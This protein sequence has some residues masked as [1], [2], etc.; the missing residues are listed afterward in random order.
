MMVKKSH[1]WIAAGMVSALMLCSGCNTLKECRTPELNLPAEIIEEGTDSASLADIEWFE[2]YSDP[3]LRH[4][5][6][7]TL[8][9]NRNLQAAVARINQLHELYGA[10]KAELLPEIGENLHIKNETKYERGHSFKR[11]SEYGALA[12][13]SWEADIWGNLRWRSK[14][15]LATYKASVEDMRALRIILI[16]EAASAYYRL[17][18]YDNELT[19]VKRTLLTRNEEK[20]KAKLR[21]EGGL[22]SEIVYLQAQVEYNTARSLIPGLERQIE[23]CESALLTLMG[24]YP[25]EK[26]ERSRNA[27]DIELVTPERIP[28]GLPSS[29]LVRRPDLRASEA[30]LSRALAAVGVAYTNRFPRL[31]ISMEGGLEAVNPGSLFNSP[32]SFINGALIGPIFDFNKRKRRYKAAVAEYD[33]ARLN[34]E[35]NVL[36]AFQEV[37][38]AVIAYRKAREATAAKNELMKAT[39]RYVELAHLQYRAGTISYIDVLDAQR[40]YLDAEIGL[41]NSMRDAMLAMITLY[42]SLGGGWSDTLS[43]ES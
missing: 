19:I 32:N 35:Q 12:T 10:A 2:F 26:L 38:D 24:R 18:A 17:V 30:R 29:L 31:T 9:N 37:N 16:A 7:E 23:V 36:V 42:K 3:H 28:V 41:S 11:I 34:Y 20:A 33:A 8:A 39:K 40:R 6:T 13:L 21:F 27:M 5:L 1:R 15:E 22:T 4:I 25:G 14:Q 43:Q